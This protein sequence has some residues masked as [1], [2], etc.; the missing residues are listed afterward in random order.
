MK[1]SGASTRCISFPLGGIGTGSIGLSGSGRLI[2]W[3]IENH[4]N[5]LSH[6][7]YSHF[8][9]K[10]ES[11][12]KLLDARILNGDLEPPFSGTPVPEVMA[13]DPFG[14]NGFGF[15]AEAQLL[16]GLPHFRNLVFNGEFPVAELTFDEPGFP[17]HVVM[18]AFNPLIPLNDFDSSLPAAAFEFEVTNTSENNIDYTLAGS[19]SN[20]LP[21]PLNQLE[22]DGEFPLLSLKSS[23]LSADD[24]GYG[25]LAVC[26][27][28]HDSSGQAAWYR[29]NWID[30]LN[31]FWN[32]LTRPGRFRNRSY[33]AIPAPEE[34]RRDTGTLA[35][36]FSL[37]PGETGRIRFVVAWYFP[38]VRNFWN[39]R[40]G[41]ASWR[42]FYA[43]K[44]PDAVGIAH[45]FMRNFDRLAAETNLFK[46]TL[47]D[48]TLPPEV[49]DAVSA[50][51]SILKSATCLRLEDGSFYGFEG[52]RSLVGSCEGSCTHVWNYAYALPFLFPKLER[53]MRE[54][55]FTFNF[56]ETGGLGFRL[57]LPVGRPAT[58]FRACADGQLGGVIKV[59]REWKISGDD[60]WLRKWYFGVKRSLEYVW[61][62]ANPDRWDPD[63]SGVL[64]GRQHHTLDVE[65]F[66]PN[67]WLTGFYLAALK[68]GAEL[69]DRVG[70]EEFAGKCRAIFERGRNRVESELFN[71]EYYIQKI[72]LTDHS[73]LTAYEGAEGYYWND[74]AGEI[75]YQIAD[76]CAI[77]QVLAAWHAALCGLGE[78]FA[79]DRVRS[80]LNAV[81]RYN[82]RKSLRNCVNFWRV[83]GLNDE[84]GT[85]ICSW[86]HGNRPA[87]PVPYATE[88][89]HGFEYQ[90]ACHLILIGEVGK[91]LEMVRAVRD[92]YDGVR[93][94]PWNEIECG[95]NYA[96]SMASYA[97]LN[98]FCGYSFH[99]PDQE[100]GFA[101]IRKSGET[102]RCFWSIGTG[103]G[104]FLEDDS[105][106][107]LEL[108]YG[109]LTLRKFRVD[110]ASEIQRVT[111]AGREIVFRTDGD[112]VLF[113]AP[114][115]LTAGESLELRCQHTAEN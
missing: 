86:P 38:N 81:Y 2:D 90:A 52:C 85:Q 109:T 84:A 99:L 41:D 45:Y 28:A 20:P 10:A 19:I 39:P 113:S 83:F 12:G 62:P 55:D 3:E 7:R 107:K 16:P 5:K 60:A 80:A 91:G 57:Q 32:D 53:S 59:Y 61:S 103:W 18:R 108:R 14:C 66:G 23:K 36:H 34:S 105:G 114:V 13:K 74:E 24:C 78:I 92:R 15:G 29:G 73:I 70:D 25:E 100:L 44:F 56:Q 98:A 95:S 87:I 48:S 110:C 97:L 31:T 6:N 11:G 17:G 43:T 94:N 71:G 27:D 72:D 77:D 89:M 96:R 8:A 111:A 40:E 79:P 49:I 51:I 35:G 37:M 64:T 47:F 112:K 54:L 88:T 63:E 1:Y 30:D 26:C 76:G 93:R 68:A 115:V 22:L 42:N 82:Y 102:F 21:L 9:I 101:P 67:S 46:E 4:P 33:P 69:A 104:C 106:V 75:K 58:N 50:N 65:L